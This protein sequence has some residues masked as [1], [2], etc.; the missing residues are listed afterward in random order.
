[1][2]TAS[3]DPFAIVAPLPQVLAWLRLG[4]VRPRG[5]IEQQLRRDL[6]QGFVG[7]LDALV[8]DLM[9][10]DDIYGANRLSRSH[11][12]KDLGVAAQESAW[13]VQYLWWNSESQSNWRDGMVRTAL[14]LEHP[15]F[16]PP[17]RAYIDQ[18]L[19]TQGADGYLGIYAPDLRDNLRGE[20]GELWAQATLFRVLLGYY[21]ATGENRVLEAVERAVQRTMAAYPQG[22]ARPFAVERPYAGL[23]HGLAFSDVLDRLAQ[24]TGEQR[25]AQY[26]LWLYAEYS[27]SETSQED[28]RYAH[29]IDPVY[30]EPT[31]EESGGLISI[32]RTWQSGERVMLR[33]HASVKLRGVRPGEYGLSHGPLLYVRPI[34]AQAQL[35]R[36]YP[37]AGFNDLY[38]LPSSA[39]PGAYRLGPQ[40][41]APFKF[42]AGQLDP[43][44]PWLTGPALVGP[45]THPQTG[46]LVTTRLVP[47]GASIL[48]QATFLMG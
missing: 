38:Y 17:V 1:M 12:R 31:G 13:Q 22:Q 24:L 20:N 36:A 14:L 41:A 2:S 27:R 3:P 29:L 46:Q 8:P 37:V 9:R 7:Q 25:Y 35:G 26:A 40:G 21:E 18:I 23:A 28:I 34:E 39:E 10:N 15:A 43:A 44:Q 5:W 47:I 33:F 19:A 16:L 32:R 42:V 48:R 11:T 6:E 4:E 30:G 45:L